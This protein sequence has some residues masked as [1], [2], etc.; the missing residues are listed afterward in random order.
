[1]L[2]VCYMKSSSPP[3]LSPRQREILALCAKNLSD[4][5]IA[6][7]LKISPNTVDTHLRKAYA[8][9]RVKSRIEAVLMALHYKY[10]NLGDLVTLAA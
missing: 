5:E 3:P 10:L 7:K 2:L 1:M 9:L 6:I 8:R 4:E